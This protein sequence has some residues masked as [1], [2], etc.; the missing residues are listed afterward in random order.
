MHVFEREVLMPRLR[1]TPDDDYYADAAIDA[2][3][4]QGP[5]H[6][7][8]SVPAETIGELASLRAVLH[9][10]EMV[11]ALQGLITQTAQHL[12]QRVQF[13]RRLIEFQALQHR[14]ADLSL[15]LHLAETAALD[16]LRRTMGD[17][18][19]E[20]LSAGE[21]LAYVAHTYQDCVEVALQLHGAMGFT[22]E[23]G[24]HRYLRHAIRVTALIAGHA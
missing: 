18:A 4:D 22:W 8:G 1:P 19:G 15:G 3:P 5:G 23:A 7:V 17:A 12:S 21:A 20:G 2:G 16:A 13:G 14:L 24:V 11:G 6:L 9:C 10:F